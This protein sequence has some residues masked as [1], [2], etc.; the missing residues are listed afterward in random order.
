[1]LHK[2]KPIIINMGGSVTKISTDYNAIKGPA[3]TEAPLADPRLTVGGPAASKI[4]G[5]YSKRLDAVKKTYAVG[6]VQ[7]TGEGSQTWEDGTC[8]CA[9]G[10]STNC[11]KGCFDKNARIPQCCNPKGMGDKGD[12]GWWDKNDRNKKGPCWGLSGAMAVDARYCK[13]NFFIGCEAMPN[14][15]SCKTGLCPQ[16]G[17]VKPSTTLIDFLYAE[18]GAEPGAPK[19]TVKY[20]SG[21]AVDKQGNIAAYAGGFVGGLIYHL[22]NDKAAYST[23]RSYVTCPY[24]RKAIM[25]TVGNLDAFRRAFGT[26]T[27]SCDPLLQDDYYSM[28]SELLMTQMKNVDCLYSGPGSN[29]SL[30]HVNNGMGT[31]VLNW[32]KNLPVACQNSL[33]LA[34]CQKNPNDDDCGCYNRV[35]DP[36]YQLVNSVLTQDLRAIVPDGCWFAPCKATSENFVN[37]DQNAV[38]LVCKYDICAQILNIV[39]SQNVNL[40]AIKAILN[41]KGNDDDNNNN[42]TGGG[43][44][45]GGGDNGGDGGDNGGS[46]LPPAAQEWFEKY[47]WVL[48]AGV[49]GLLVLVGLVY[50][51]RKMFGKKAAA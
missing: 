7:Q 18:P 19:Q 42:N 31:Y 22:V 46:V 24:D 47:W 26:G 17:T 23:G 13:A 9:A 35:N 14:C 44:D 20:D 30:A 27:N 37:S 2:S 11:P 5:Y 39:D 48:L 41:C 38:N 1:L 21:L 50:L 10:G 49:G 45:N 15:T 8:D 43:G 12:D 28:M 32:F 25:S 3:Q 33:G 34:Y 36:D 16:V 6:L 40:S 51:L 29:C 4:G